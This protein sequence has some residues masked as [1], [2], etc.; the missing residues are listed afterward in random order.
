MSRPGAARHAAAVLAAVALASGLGSTV[1][2]AA[3]HAAPRAP[4]A[5]DSSAGFRVEKLATGV[6]ALIRKEPLGLA[7]HSNRLFIIGTRDVVVVDTPF[8]RSAAREE[9]RALRKLTPKPVRYVINTHWHDDHVY[10]NQA[11]RDAWPGVEFIAQAH[12]R[13]DLAKIGADNRR[14]QIEGGPDAI[15]AF[16]EALATGTS[17][18]GTP[19][20][21]DERAAYRSTIAIATEY[22]AEAPGFQPALPTITFGDR[23]TLEHDGRTIEI[24][25][26]GR[27]VTRGDAIVYLPT[28]GVLAAG[29]LVDDPVPFSY[30]AD[31]L[32]WIAAL[33]S[34]TALAPRVVVPGHGP[35]LQ[36]DASIR[37]LSRLLA[38]IE[39]GARVAAARGDTLAPTVAS[40]HLDD[41]KPAAIGSNRMLDLLFTS[42]FAGPLV[43]AEFVRARAR[44]PKDPSPARR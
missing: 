10:A 4:A 19:M 27:A 29:D 24:R 23:L 35:V 25:S 13:E 12:T 42:Y 40:L 39:D 36:G 15:A 44:G 38:A 9:I 32:G 16:R 37:A 6:Y 33:D 8:T 34:L 7:N 22:V 17:L 11:Y 1:A 31:A 3:A 2:R 18:Q 5:A 20:S 30:G 28:E 26:F 43:Q 21:A 14:R 41:L